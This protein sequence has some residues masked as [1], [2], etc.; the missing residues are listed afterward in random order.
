ML[1]QHASA[2]QN[3]IVATG[4]VL[5]S[6]VLFTAILTPPASAQVRG[7]GAGQGTFA[8][9]PGYAGFAGSGGRP[10]VG[11]G[12]GRSG[13]SFAG[14]PGHFHRG[15]SSGRSGVI[16][17]YPYY[18]SDFAYDSEEPGQPP[19]LVKP[20][21]APVPPA[22]PAAPIEPL[23]I[24]WQGD[25]FERM[26]LSE[27]KS[28]AEPGKPDPS[29]KAEVNSSTVAASTGSLRAQRKVAQRLEKPAAI[30][31]NLAHE[32]PPAVLVFHDG[33][34]EELNSYTIM[35]GTIYS[36]AD[37]WTTGSWTKKI[38]IADLD[39]PATLK[40]NHEHGLNFVLPAGPNEVVTRP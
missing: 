23:L 30:S 9:Q 10:G 25:H 7:A 18:Y 31:G 15:R 21:A 35:S 8:V 17:P 40:L 12:A 24:E 2:V 13:G 11:S 39:V 33:R 22:P 4:A 19:I 27:K 38:Q 34:T 36:K 14:G 5:A 28:G 37:Y 6:A 1:K 32:L 16:L 3:A 29:A 26:T 20:A